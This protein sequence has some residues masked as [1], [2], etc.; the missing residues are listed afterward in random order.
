M[1]LFEM[2]NPPKVAGLAKLQFG[3][4]GRTE[5]PPFR[6]GVDIV[7][8]DDE[9]AEFFPLMDG[10][11]F[12]V[13]LTQE[14]DYNR[15]VERQFWFGGTDEQPFLVR[16]KD[17]PFRAYRQKGEP[18]FYTSLKPDQVG[19]FEEQFKAPAK[20]QGDMFAVQLPH[21]WEE[22]IK[23]GRL[24]NGRTPEPE[25]VKAQS[26]FGT[27]HQIEG[28]YCENFKVYG[29][30]LTVIEG[31]LKAPDHEIVKLERPHVIV[32]AQNLWAPQEAD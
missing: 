32:Q 1:R 25:K 10:E 11:Q 23:A 8:P 7:L 6:K 29:L 27:R 18:A 9:E 21:S 26:L 12:L 16:L 14:G 28:L 19:K 15:N 2:K 4:K 20:R 31:L 3:Y 17:P 5:R 13:R 22:M 30:G 24:A